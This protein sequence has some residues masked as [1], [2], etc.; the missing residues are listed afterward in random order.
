MS[1]VIIM[2]YSL[3]RP[4][5]FE[6]IYWL[7]PATM[8]AAPILR[9]KMVSE[10]VPVFLRRMTEDDLRLWSASSNMFAVL[11]LSIVVLRESY[12]V[13]KSQLEHLDID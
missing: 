8:H 2:L 10:A 13:R 6:V 5:Y 9:L 12:P 3:D 4:A 7:T 1:I 11:S